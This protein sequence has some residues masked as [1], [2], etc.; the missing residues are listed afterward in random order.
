M[1]LVLHKFGGSSLATADCFRQVAKIVIGQQ[2]EH[3]RV[4]V[5]VSAMG[6]KPKVTDMLLG[7]VDMALAGDE[8]GYDGVIGDIRKRHFDTIA[9][10]ID[11]AGR[12]KLE[13]S[14]SK[15]LEDI[16]HILKAASIMK[17]ADARVKGIIGGHGELWSAQILA[18]MLSQA[19]SSGGSGVPYHFLDARKTLVVTEEE[20]GI[21]VLWEES[22][23]K[24]PAQIE[25]A[26]GGQHSHM[27]ITG[28]IASTTDGVMTTLQRDGSDFSASIFGKLLKAESVTIWTDVSG[29]LSADPRKVSNARYVS[30]LSY[31]EAMELAYFGAKVI[32]PSTMRPG[33][34]VQ[35]PKS[36]SLYAFV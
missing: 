16:K 30:H 21:E 32:H 12:N 1:S 9:E 10:L 33:K 3:A 19:T 25:S 15:D 22:E 4:A 20:M 13:A 2:N 34:V 29:V 6:G 28:F 18:A 31:N 8:A 7:M 11:D 35:Y 26:S 17:I 24:L 36:C 14:I 27:V 5:V 23:K